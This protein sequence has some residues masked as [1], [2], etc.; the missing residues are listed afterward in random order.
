MIENTTISPIRPADPHPRRRVGTRCRSGRRPG[1]TTSRTDGEQELDAGREG[2]RLDDADPAAEAAHDRDLHRAREPG[3]GCESDGRG[4]HATTD[5][6]LWN[7][8]NSFPSVSV[9]R[10][11]QPMWGIAMRSSASPPSSCTFSIEASM[12]SVSK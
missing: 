11:N 10:A 6:S 4:G 2:Q 1:V 7:R 5:S 3:E 8:L 12:S 9:Q